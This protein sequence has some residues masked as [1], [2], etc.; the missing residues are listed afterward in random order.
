MREVV[1]DLNQASIPFPFPRV[2]E[3]R[4]LGDRPER[5][6]LLLR[7]SPR[8]LEPA[9]S[10]R[11]RQLHLR[12]MRRLLRH[13]SRDLSAAERQHQL[14]LRQLE[15]TRSPR[16]RHLRPR[17]MRRLLRRA[18]RESSTAKRQHQ[19]PQPVAYL[20]RQRQRWHSFLF[21]LQQ[22][23]ATHLEILRGSATL[24]NQVSTL[25]ARVTAAG[26]SPGARANP[27]HDR[28]WRVHVPLAQG[29]AHVHPP[30]TGDG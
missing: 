25:M 13:S 16:H 10:P 22:V 1:S 7:A 18:S 14:L 28:Y 8:Q 2:A 15:P 24:L 20:V 23:P 4:T 17:A 12:V 6:L 26:P 9:R 29:H 21:P 11:R 27:R 3:G 30:A 19:P 5:L